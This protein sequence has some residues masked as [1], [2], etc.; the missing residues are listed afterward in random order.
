MLEASRQEPLPVLYSPQANRSSNFDQQQ[1]HQNTNESSQR[2]PPRT[3]PFVNP[4]IQI[5]T[6]QL[7]KRSHQ[8]SYIFLITNFINSL[9]G[10]F[11]NFNIS[12]GCIR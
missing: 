11:H 3:S 5:M 10:C 7:K 9:Y 4:N 6:S 12:I 1:Q 8:V 2:D